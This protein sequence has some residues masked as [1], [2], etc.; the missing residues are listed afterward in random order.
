VNGNEFVIEENVLE[1]TFEDFIKQQSDKKEDKFDVLL[2]TV[3]DDAIKATLWYLR[4]KHK[5]LSTI[6][7]TSY[8]LAKFGFRVISQIGLEDM[9]KEMKRIY[10]ND[11]SRVGHIV[12]NYYSC[13]ISPRPHKVYSKFPEWLAGKISNLSVDLGLKTSQLFFLLIVYGI[14]NCNWVPKH[15]RDKCQQEVNHFLWWIEDR[16]TILSKY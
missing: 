15:Y 2:S 9:T 13:I 8:Y 10:E 16:K 14:S 5:K 7:K 11:P 4:G 6:S 1:I 3:V 12:R